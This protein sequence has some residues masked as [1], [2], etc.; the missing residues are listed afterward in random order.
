MDRTNNSIIINPGVNIVG[1]TFNE[2]QRLNGYHKEYYQNNKEQLKEKYKEKQE[3]GVGYI[4]KGNNFKSAVKLFQETGKIDEVVKEKLGYFEFNGKQVSYLETILSKPDYLEFIESK[5]W[6]VSNIKDCI[7]NRIKRIEAAK[8]SETDIQLKT[9]HHYTYT[10]L[11][12]LAN[13]N[14]VLVKDI[15]SNYEYLEYS[16]KTGGLYKSDCLTIKTYFIRSKK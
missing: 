5:K 2:L 11:E 6:N 12:L 9:G 8:K 3:R 10:E 14:S 13:K 16:V 7:N 1:N 15:L 4:K